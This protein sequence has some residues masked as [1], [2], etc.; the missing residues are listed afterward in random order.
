MSRRV[1]AILLL[2]PV[3]LTAAVLVRVQMNRSANRGPIVLTEREASLLSRN[4]DYSAATL[5]LSW[6][7]LEPQ[8]SW[9][10]RQKLQTLGFDVSVDPVS[11]AAE[12]HYRRQLPRDV[13][14][15]F[16]LDGPAWQAVLDAL[17]RNEQPREEMSSLLRQRA[18]RLVPVDADEAPAR[19]AAR[20]PNAATHLIA[21]GVM[22]VWWVRTADA[23]PYVYGSI[24]DVSP[25]RIHVP[26]LLGDALPARSD[27]Q[28]RE[29]YR[30][31]VM[32]G[33]AWEPWVVATTG[34]ASRS[35]VTA[36]WTFP[37]KSGRSSRRE[38]TFRPGTP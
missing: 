20:Y 27:F 28:D 13:Y 31:D 23:P 21:R 25:R 9:A 29:R 5:S 37:R 19:L 1:L 24:V 33:R 12:E 4:D 2:A 8:A 32:Y 17:D 18:S 38:R 36:G 10:T 15:A 26:P 34:S 3:A 22:R 30:V 35:S 6:S 11:D 16:E 7:E 14:V